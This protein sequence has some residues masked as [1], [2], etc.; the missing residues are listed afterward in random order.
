MRVLTE[1]KKLMR[2]Y[3]KE[4]KQLMGEKRKAD[5]TI[6]ERNKKLMRLCLKERTQLMRGDWQNWCRK[7]WIWEPSRGKTNMNNKKGKQTID[8]STKFVSTLKS[9]VIIESYWWTQIIFGLELASNAKAES[10]WAWYTTS[11]TESFDKCR[12][13]LTELTLPIQRQTLL[14]SVLIVF[15][16]CLLPFHNGSPTEISWK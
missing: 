2:L 11:L 3:L 12:L 14:W 10:Q 4:R 9:K 16:W 1:K 5:E 6:F 8:R 15:A 13:I 7:R